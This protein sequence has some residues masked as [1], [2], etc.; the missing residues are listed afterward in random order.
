MLDT[1]AG[2]QAEREE[3]DWL[4]TSG[5]LGRSENLARVLKYVCEE[6]FAGRGQIIKEY[7]IATEALGRR[8]NFDPQIDTI[9]RVTVHA[10]RKRLADIYQNEGAGR[11]MRIIMPPGRYCPRFVSAVPLDARP[12]V[13]AEAEA[14][15]AIQTATTN[16]PAMESSGEQML[17]RRS[18]R[19]ISRLAI[20]IAVLLGAVAL[21]VTAAIF[22]HFNILSRPTK[23]A[24]PSQAPLPR[25]L[26]HA[27]MGADRPP[28]VDHS[29]NTWSV[30][31]YC[32]GGTNI[33][34]PAQKIEGTLDSWMYQ[35]GVRGIAHCAFPVPRG[36]YE[37]HFYFAETSDLQP[38]TKP[39]TLSINAGP[40]NIIDVVNDAGGAGTATSTVFT[41][42]APEN[43]G[44]IHVDFV[45]EV[46]LLN[47]VE[48]LPVGSAQLLPI[49]IAVGSKQFV[50]NANQVWSSDRYFSG[51]RFGLPSESPRPTGLGLY[52]SD[53][54]G[55]FRY[56]IPVVP[57]A[58]YRVKLYFREPWFGGEHGGIGGPGSR[59][60]DVTC[61]GVMLLKNF[62]VLASGGGEPVVKTFE[63]IQGSA[64][65]RLELSFVPVK[66]YAVV[67]AIEV[68][69]QD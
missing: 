42:I 68:L 51:G 46:S 30:G 64:G 10:L 41:G 35:G 63:N 27:L 65:G 19:P 61:N 58:R 9:V 43:D 54:V 24:V 57:Y 52:E 12:S 55:R 3:L 14:P 5:V 67:N 13:A 2:A 26:I 38:A 59:V 40:V 56:N 50:D 47:A 66:N 44:A 36:L 32:Q 25:N 60:F 31:N 53:R 33:A 37:L 6:R 21:L 62:D 69:P 18:S 39:A 22:Y 49:R 11:D 34:L 23:S 29:G 28:A 4:L 7:S 17:P 8:S 16:G 20:R 15:A 1:T 45:S 48:I